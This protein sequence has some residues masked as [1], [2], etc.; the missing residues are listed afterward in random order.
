MD[1]NIIQG[2]SILT[3]VGDAYMGKLIGLTPAN[4]I[5]Y[6]VYLCKFSSSNT[7]TT[8]TLSLDL[9]GYYNPYPIVKNTGAA[10]GIGDL[11][12]DGWYLIMFS[13]NKFLKLT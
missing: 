8:P 11:E 3:N 1:F 9:N 5:N 13:V 12:I 6:G 2:K 10:L 7:T 4:Y